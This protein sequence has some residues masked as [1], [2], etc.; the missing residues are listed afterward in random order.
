MS[1]LLPLP[2]YMSFFFFFLLQYTCA[3]GKGMAPSGLR[4]SH[5]GLPQMILS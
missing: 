2:F 5:R 3:N 4:A 1:S